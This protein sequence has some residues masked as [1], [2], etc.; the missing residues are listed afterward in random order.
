[1]SEYANIGGRN[2]GNQLRQAAIIRALSYPDGLPKRSF[3]LARID[4]MVKWDA[5]TGE[6]STIKYR[7]QSEITYVSYDEWS[8]VECQTK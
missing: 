8:K 4:C 5:D 2:Q 7:Q 3:I 6:V 1:M